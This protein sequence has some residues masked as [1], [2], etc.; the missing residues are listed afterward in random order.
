VRIGR[1]QLLL[2][3]NADAVTLRGEPVEATATLPDGRVVRVRVGVPEDSYISRREL[4]TVDLELYDG[5][6]HLAA[7]NTVLGADQNSEARELV[8]EVVAGLES[9]ELEP[10]AGALERLAD[11]AR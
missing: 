4:D 5:E 10:T 11:Q 1:L 9:G 7:V 3:E 2:A 8:R 6:Q